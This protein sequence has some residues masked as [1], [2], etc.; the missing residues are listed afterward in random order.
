MKKPDQDEKYINGFDAMTLRNGGFM[1]LSIISLTVF[2]LILGFFPTAI[3]NF[4]ITAASA[5]FP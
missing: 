2:V 3:A 1:K 4:A 5:L